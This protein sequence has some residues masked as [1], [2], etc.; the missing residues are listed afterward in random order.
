MKAHSHVLLISARSVIAIIQ[1]GTSTICLWAFSYNIGLIRR[2]LVD[3]D[4]HYASI[5]FYYQ[6]K[7]PNGPINVQYLFQFPKIKVT[8]CIIIIIS[9]LSYFKVTLRKLFSFLIH[10]SLKI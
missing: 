4:D 5:K 10:C 7:K 2:S 8:F 1:I 9:Y 3:F 6:K